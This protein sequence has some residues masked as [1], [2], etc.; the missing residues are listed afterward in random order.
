MSHAYWQKEQWFYLP[1]YS[2]DDSNMHEMI[3][4]P[5]CHTK[6]SNIAQMN[7]ETKQSYSLDQN[8]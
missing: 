2:E 4:D 8:I 1:Q 5:Y 7:N 3:L 6:G